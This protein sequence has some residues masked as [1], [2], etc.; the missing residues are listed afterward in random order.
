[1]IGVIAAAILAGQQAEPAAPWRYGCEPG[2]FEA[3]STVFAADGTSQ[4]SHDR[5]TQYCFHEGRVEITE[6][7]SL[8]DKGETVFRGASITVW[9]ADLSKGRT[10]WAMVGVDGWTDIRLRW[11]DGDL[12]SEGEGHDPEGAFLERW[13][14]TFAPGGDQHFVMDRSYDAGKNWTAPKNII[15]YLKS[16]APPPPLPDTWTE[17]F[18]FAEGLVGDDGVIFL[19]GT[20]WGAFT[21]DKKGAPNGFRFASVAPKDGTW[22]WRTLTWSAAKGVVNV[23]DAPL[24]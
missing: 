19:D 13:R 20:A 9:N 10:L 3:W 22:V 18:A 7:R 5:A 14:T 23:E 8:N 17:Q 24:N 11:E 12:V 6:Y 2:V 4:S 1:M 16:T 21:L 15:E